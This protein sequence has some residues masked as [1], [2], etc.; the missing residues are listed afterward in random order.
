MTINKLVFSLVGI[1]AL[2]ASAFA[3]TAPS[4]KGAKNVA[5]EIAPVEQDLGLTLAVGYD[6][7]YFFRGLNL[8]ED[9]V[10]TSLDW[11]L[12]LTQNLRLDTGAAFGTTAGDSSKFGDFELNDVSFQ[13]LELSAQLVATLGPVEIGAG[14]RWYNNMGDL[15]DIMEDGHE[16]GVNLATKLGPLNFGVGAYHDF[17]IDGWYFE[18]AVNSE[19]KLCDRV[20]LVPGANIGYADQ[21]SYHFNVFGAKPQVDSFTAVTVSLAL[22]I[23]LSKHATLTPYI[24]GNLPLNDLKDVDDN[25]LYGGVKLAVKF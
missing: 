3:G 7:H 23:K 16:V 18:A 15:G 20:S 4:G 17:S 13:R 25:Q 2:A 11:T 9:W 19:I 5:P 8:A 1:A 12:P 10:S 6:T 24:A 14:Y 21:Y 22:P